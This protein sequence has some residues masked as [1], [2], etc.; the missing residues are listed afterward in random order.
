MNSSYCEHDPS[1]FIIVIEMQIASVL[2]RSVCGINPRFY[3]YFFNTHI[4]SSTYL[5]IKSLLGS[6]PRSLS[7]FHRIHG[8]GR[9]FFRAFPLLDQR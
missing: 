5:I 2:V 3:V 4:I 1:E 7:L 6:P 9:I 8:K